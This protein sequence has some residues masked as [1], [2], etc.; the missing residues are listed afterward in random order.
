MEVVQVS[1]EDAIRSFDEALADRCR[2][3]DY[4]LRM[5][6]LLLVYDGLNL[7]CSK[8]KSEPLTSFSES[9]L[10][11]FV[12]S[13]SPE[14]IRCAVEEAVSYLH[15]YPLKYF[16]SDGS[17]INPQKAKAILHGVRDELMRG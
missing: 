4:R 7:Y 10:Q 14:A 3:L 12:E 1:Y 11:G 2:A 6:F 5:W 17:K 8:I 15:R 16:L 13:T 9:A